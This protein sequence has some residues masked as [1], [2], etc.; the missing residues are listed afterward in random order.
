MRSVGPKR[1]PG[2]GFRHQVARFSAAHRAASLS[3]SRALELERW[4]ETVV[5]LPYIGRCL[6]RRSRNY[7]SWSRPATEPRRF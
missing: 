2:S 1:D 4:Q 5:A 6:L 3:V 7:S